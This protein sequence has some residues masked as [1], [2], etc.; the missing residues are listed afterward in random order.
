MQQHAFF[1]PFCRDAI[2]QAATQAASLC[3][4]SQEAHDIERWFGL[5]SSALAIEELRP[6]EYMKILTLAK[7]S[8]KLEVRLNVSI[9]Q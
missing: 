5:S 9:R 1:P 2:L 6:H 4:W 7:A 3:D 8:D